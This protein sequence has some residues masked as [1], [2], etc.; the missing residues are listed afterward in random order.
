MSSAG[1]VYKKYGKFMIEE[2]VKKVYQR[3]TP[4]LVTVATKLFYKSYIS[5]IDAVSNGMEYT[6]VDNKLYTDCKT[7]LTEIN[8]YCMGNETT[9]FYFKT[10]VNKHM[11]RVLNQTVEIA[12]S[13][14][15]ILEDAK[16]VI[17]KPEPD[18]RILFI[19]AKDSD[20]RQ[21]IDMLEQELNCPGQFLFYVST[22]VKYCYAYSIEDFKYK[23]RC[24]F[25]EEWR[26]LSDSKL[27]EISGIGTANY[28][29]ASGFMFSAIH[30]EDV[31]DACRKSITNN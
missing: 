26:G 10:K 13:Y 30:R 15:D 18:N 16:K 22:G 25:K 1:L 20:V 21:L 6:D 31:V 5:V 29:H 24:Q 2:S 8:D 28:C 17:K 19:N 4:K 3:Y 14:A 12:G 7:T 27:V 11:E 23:Q 9:F